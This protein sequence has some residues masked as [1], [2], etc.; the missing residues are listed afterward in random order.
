MAFSRPLGLAQSSM[1]QYGSP[2]FLGVIA[3]TTA[4]N[5]STTA[6]PFVI[7]PGAVLLLIPDADVQ[8]LGQTTAAAATTTTNGVPLI[9]DTER[10]VFLAE[11][12]A[13]VSCVGAANT[14][15]WQLR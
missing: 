1:A 12:E 4:T 10:I 9:Q 2:R 13:Y 14:S 8:W 15:V 3:S 6:V 11:D 7:P 5:N